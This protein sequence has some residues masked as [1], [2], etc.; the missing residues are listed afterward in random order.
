[1]F[2]V[3]A[4]ILMVD[5]SGFSRSMLKSALREL[6]FWKILEAKDVAD[7]QKCLEEDE[8]KAD[9]VHLIICD[10]QMPEKTGL[11]FIK[12]LRDQERFKA[13]PI[14]MLTTSHEKTVIVEAGKLGVSNY[15]IKPFD[16]NTL[17]VRLTSTWER[18]GQK[19]YE[20]NQ[21]TKVV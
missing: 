10:Q 4:K 15:M 13:M 8:Q 16:A 2:P 21:A 11:E 9:P 20:E 3:D 19:Y 14:I 5:D 18:A 7:A 6:K 1:M 17:R 12:W